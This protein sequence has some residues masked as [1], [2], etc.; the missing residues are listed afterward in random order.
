MKKKI[1]KSLEKFL[2]KKILTI[3]KDD[4]RQCGLSYRK[5]NYLKGI[6]KKIKDDRK[7]FTRLNELSDKDA[8]NKL[9]SLYGIGQW[10]AEMFLIFKLNRMNI[11]PLGDVGLINSFCKN[12]KVNKNIFLDQIH[13]YKKM[14]TILYSC[15]LVFVERY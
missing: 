11:L 9:T 1:I 13:K 8:I 6:A 10:S 12:Y 4:L 15:N 2:L 3:I 5:V 14:G 7:F